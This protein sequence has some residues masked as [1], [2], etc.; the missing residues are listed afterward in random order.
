MIQKKKIL[1]L[2]SDTG[3]GH[4]NAAQALTLAFEEQHPQQY[5]IKTID[6]LTEGHKTFD[7]LIKK[8]YSTTVNKTSI[9]HGIAFHLT[10]KNFSWKAITP[11]SRLI[12]N[13]LKNKLEEEQ[14]DLIVSVHPLVNHTI[15]QIKK[16]SNLTTPFA[17]I[18]TDPFTVHRGWAE[19]QADLLIVAS[20]EAKERLL[21]ARVP[22][23][24]I[25]VTGLPIKP[26]FYTPPKNLSAIREEFTLTKKYTILVTGGGEGAGSTL[27]VI[28][29]LTAR[30][31]N[32]QVIVVC[33][34]N[35]TLK[36]ALKE[37]P[38]TALGYTTR[39]HDLLSVS[40]LVI[41]KAGP[42]TIEEAAIKGLPL[43]MTSYIH[44]QEK[45]NIPYAQQR[46][47]AY[48]E[49]K[50]QKI[51]NI[52]EE[53]LNSRRPKRKPETKKTAAVYKI[54]NEL[55]QLVSST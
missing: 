34:R 41:G 32:I 18:I 12:H 37:Y 42:A 43:I 51:V 20:K 3:G 13:N 36:E 53:E 21:K 15:S 24:N 17:I 6:F 14:P 8:A 30:H 50:P 47:R 45:G 9:P 1:I 22:E 35:E 44:G 40:D 31:L 27:P 10:N 2:S 48:Y 55:H 7:R 19:P 46:T 16:E 23:N 28:K 11:L 26:V 33:G 39:M 38:V 52:I 49:T 29:E 25:L 5:D 4:R 54:V